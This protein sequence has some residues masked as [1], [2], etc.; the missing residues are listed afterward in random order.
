MLHPKVYKQEKKILDYVRSLGVI[1]TPGDINTILMAF[2]HKSFAADYKEKYEYNERLEF[3][4]DGI[5]WAIV[6]S[7]LFVDFPEMAESDMT[8]YK[9]SLVREETLAEMARDIKLWDYVFIS[10][11]EESMNGRDKDSILSDTL[12]ALI[13]AL[14]LVFDFSVVEEFIKKYLYS[15]LSDIKTRPSKS[16]KSMIQEIIQ[17]KHK[18]LPVYK[19]YEDEATSN[20][21]VTRYKSE[22]FVLGNKM[23]EGFGASK[24]K[25]QEE[26]ACTLYWLLEK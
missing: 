11:G 7:F 26:A 3:L 21:N 12:E 14:F 20:G 8:L 17:K 18:I 9:I 22:I 5:L 25:A 6:N 4:W 10:N 23:A 15:K 13:W 1:E 2:V 19:E 16:Y 24:K